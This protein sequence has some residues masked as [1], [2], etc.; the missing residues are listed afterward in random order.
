MREGISAFFRRIGEG[1]NAP[2]SERERE[3]NLALRGYPENHNYKIRGGT[4][5]PCMNLHRRWRIIAP[6]LPNPLTSL[7]DIG[8]SKGFFV[9]SAARREGCERAVGIDVHE[10]FIRTS[11]EVRDF[12]KQPNAT[13]HLAGLKQVADDPAQFGGPFQTVMLLNVYHYLYWGS[14]LD[15]TACR[16]HA[17]LFSRLA[18]VCVQ[19]LIFSSPLEVPECPGEIQRLAEQ[20][21]GGAEYTAEKFLAA[22]R[23]F[24]EVRE[25]GR[26][27]RRPVFSMEKRASAG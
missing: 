18:K 25:V 9:L 10:P 15:S 5:A 19:R 7:L 1:G 22:A 20:S 24:F 23:K 3:L 16:D 8:S 6:L 14:G 2:T 11:N 21:G 26:S 13:F 12:L 27:G 4:L 17:K